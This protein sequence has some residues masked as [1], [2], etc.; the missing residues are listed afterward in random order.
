MPAGVPFACK[1]ADF[2]LM[3]AVLRERL[4]RKLVHLAL[5]FLIRKSQLSRRDIAADRRSFLNNQTVTGEMR[6]GE[7][8]RGLPAFPAHPKRFAKAGRAS[9]PG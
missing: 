5:D 4:P 9:G 7:R 6:G 1:I 2:I 3:K 8:N